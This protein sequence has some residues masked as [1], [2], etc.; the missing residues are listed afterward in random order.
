MQQSLPSYAKE[1]LRTLAPRISRADGQL[2]IDEAK[3]YLSDEFEQATVDAALE[4]L[5]RHGYL[6]EVNGQLRV[7]EEET[8]IR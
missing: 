7:T 1:V 3:V 8:N 5:L 4:Q 2:S 6:Y